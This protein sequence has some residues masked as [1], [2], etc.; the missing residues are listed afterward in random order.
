MRTQAVAPIREADFATE[1]R[2][3]LSRCGQK[4]LPSKYLYD[5]VGSALF[6]VICVLPEYGLWRAGARLLRCHAKE[7]VERLHPPTIIA[8]PGSGSGKK[9]RYLLEA[10]AK[11]Q[12]TTYTSRVRASAFV[13]VRERRSG[14]RA[15]TSTH[16]KRSVRWR[17]GR[18]T[19]ATHSGWTTNGRLRKVSSRHCEKLVGVG[20]VA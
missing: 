13:S 1:V 12:R 14:P 18:D 20:L 16:S 5:D 17:R 7:L 2:L 8:E 3:G 4:E 15:H 6:E 10:L 19:A 11:K 9:T